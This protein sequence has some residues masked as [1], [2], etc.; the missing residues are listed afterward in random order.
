MHLWSVFRLRDS[1]ALIAAF[2]KHI[3]LLE[4]ASILLFLNGLTAILSLIKKE[5]FENIEF[6]SKLLVLGVFEHLRCSDSP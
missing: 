1:I 2:E 6:W 5:S 3:F 4:D